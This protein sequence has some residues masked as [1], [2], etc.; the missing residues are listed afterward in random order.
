MIVSITGHRPD[1]L[2]GYA[3]CETHEIIQKR[4]A[5]ALYELRPDKVISGMALGIDQWAAEIA[6]G[7]GIPVIAAIPFIEQASAWPASSQAVYNDLLAKCS[8]I[9]YVNAPGY[10]G[11]KMQTRNKWMVDRADVILAVWDGTSG[12][13]A[14]CIDYATKQKKPIVN[15]HPGKTGIYV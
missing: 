13:T 7:L 9:V 15:V 1:K 4:L 11:W 8:E 2:G 3:H 5:Y 6:I 14:N 10:A 12:G